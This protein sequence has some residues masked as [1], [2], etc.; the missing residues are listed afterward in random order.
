[1]NVRTLPLLAAVALV[2]VVLLGDVAGAVD[3]VP[4]GQRQLGQ[5]IVE[6]VYDAQHAGAIGFIKTPEHA[7][8]RSDEAARRPLYLPVYPEGASVGALICPHVPVDTCPD[9][10]PVIAGLAQS[11]APEVYGVGVVGHDHLAALRGAGGEGAGVIL[12]PVVVLFTSAAAARQHLLTEADVLAA[13][14]RGDAMTIALPG[15][16]LHG[17][18]V[19]TEVWTLAT[20]VE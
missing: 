8:V 2:T 13:V 6:P 16:A 5:S 12:E 20:P 17:E 11:V 3:Q 10:G 15:A 19:P 9:H 18:L 1:M 14:A 4:S 7:P